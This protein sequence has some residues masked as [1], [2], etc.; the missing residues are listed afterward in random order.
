MTRHLT[1]EQAL[2][3]ARRAV[4]GPVEIRDIGLLDAAIHRPQA[5]VFGRDAY[6]D[7]MTKA[8]A[9]L[10]SLARNHP[11]VDGNKRLAWLATWV[12]C[13]KNGVDLDPPDDDAFALVMSVAAG[14]LD[15]V[16]EIARRLAGFPGRRA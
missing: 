16:G 8:A 12:F 4:G 15:D 10:H 9:L 14:E 7:L 13:A 2:R 6:P 1:T 11:L 3:I 5:S